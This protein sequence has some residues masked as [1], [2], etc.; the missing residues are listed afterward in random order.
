MD[1]KLLKGWLAAAMTRK[2]TLIWVTFVLFFSSSQVLL[3]ADIDPSTM[4]KYRQ[5]KATLEQMSKAKAGIYAR[6]VLDHAQRTIAR[7][8]EDMDSK[9]EN[10]V[11]QALDMAALQI[12]QANAKV[13]EREA[14]EKTAVTRAK[15][16]KLEQRLANI[17]AGKGEEK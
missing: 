9:K 11:R 16:D 6:D 1:G 14:A 5:V 17:L 2:N 13:E 12:E 7:A 15:V 8:Q 4:E 3:A 10:A